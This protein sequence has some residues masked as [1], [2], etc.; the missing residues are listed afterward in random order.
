VRRCGTCDGLRVFCSFRGSCARKQGG[1]LC[2][3]NVS[4]SVFFLAV[5]LIRISFS[6]SRISGRPWNA[7][8]KISMGLV[9]VPVASMRIFSTT[10]GSGAKGARPRTMPTIINID[11]GMES[12][13]FILPCPCRIGS[14]GAG[15]VIVHQLLLHFF[16]EIPSSW[17]T[18]TE[19]SSID[20]PSV[21]TVLIPCCI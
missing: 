13:H 19:S 3:T 10:C 6:V 18:W 14:R 7:R 17:V 5:R 20:L 9:R 15:T 16:F 12:S 1:G 21:L 2:P 4:Y 8:S 11:R